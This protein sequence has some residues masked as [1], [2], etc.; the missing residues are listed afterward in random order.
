MS[1]PLRVLIIEDSPDDA[2][3][4]VE[5]L[6]GGG[7]EVAYEVVAS[8]DALRRFLEDQTWDLILADHSLP[9]FTSIEAL[10]IAKQLRPDIPLI[11]VSGTISEDAAVQSI[12]AGAADY[13]S[14]SNI[15]RLVPAVT[16]EMREVDARKEAERTAT[17]LRQSERRLATIFNAS[18]V[19]IAISTL[20]DWRLVDVNE[21]FLNLFGV[22]RNEIIGHTSQ[23]LAPLLQH[24]E[25]MRLA[26]AVRVQRNLKGYELPIRSRSGEIRTVQLSIALIELDDVPYSVSFFHDITKQR[27]MEEA[28][29]EQRLYA[30]A[31]QET[32]SILNST[33]ELDRVHDAILEQ[34]V[35]VVPHDGAKISLIEGE[36][37]RVIR[38]RGFDEET[39]TLLLPLE[40]LPHLRYVMRTRKPFIF[41][42]AAPFYTK[43]K[44]PDL[45]WVQTI[46]AAPI[47]MMNSVLGFVT[48]YSAT[49]GI[50]R[51][52][53][54]R[55]LQVFA[56]QASLAIQNAQL[57][58][59]MVRQ[60][61]ELE[62]RVALRTRQLMDSVKRI[63]TI[64]NSTSDAVLVANVHGQI[65][66]TNQAFEETFGYQ[67]EELYGEPL[68]QIV[69]EGNTEGFASAMR[70]VLQSGHPC[71]LELTAQRKNGE[72]FD[73]DV[74][75][76]SLP[77][78][79][80]ARGVLCSVRDI[81]ERK[82]LEAELRRSLENEREL[83]QLRAHFSSMLSHEFRNPLSVIQF[84]SSVL[85]DFNDRL[86]PEKREEHLLKIQAQIRLLVNMLDDH[87]LVTRSEKVAASFNP[88][89]VDM[90]V[91]CKDV[92][93][94]MQ[95]IE[96][97]HEIQLSIT[98]D[99]RPV[100]IDPRLFRQALTNLLSNAAKYSPEG[101]KIEVTLNCDPDEIRI[102]V[103][104][105]GMGIPDE[106]QQRLFQT[107]FRA[108][109][110]GSIPGTGLGLTIIKQTVALHSGTVSFES[111][112]NE[113]TTFTV[114]IP[115][116]V[117]QPTGT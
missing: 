33:L 68:T 2:T 40:R 110:V 88:G 30:E 99:R 46:L 39:V 53:H 103:R 3:L 49:P 113:G 92:I 59:A 32:A 31:L 8:S 43:Y 63:E 4:M 89:H 23:E 13:I 86:T 108:S 116:Q 35:R 66:E 105:H 1:L 78:S 51:D 117:S 56:D 64:L 97:A 101:E 65:E 45:G 36:H 27:R 83:G 7:Y 80:D 91:F 98:G 54:A 22:T 21:P 58:D 93:E 67:K 114:T 94:E 95:S 20:A 102:A 19:A 10:A 109:N 111:K 82:K 38:H 106:D 28:E 29:R 16:R 70:D 57:Y 72:G 87:L 15:H 11:I 75:I 76:S 73:A 79:S 71:R 24:D 61:R 52:E 26:N 81:T 44:V 55:R 90:H 5:E 14:K 112:V 47:L 18:P 115:R 50:F 42:N 104:D 85:K 25:F 69:H 96:T 9:Q 100:R 41:R 17:Q 12:K 84:S 77:A 107:F 34:I 60:S 37:A 74:A 62:Q 48:V 6:H